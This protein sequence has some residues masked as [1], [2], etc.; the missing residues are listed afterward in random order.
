MDDLSVIFPVYNERKTIERVLQDWDTQLTKLKIPFRIIVCE[1]GSTDGTSQLLRQLVKRFGIKLL[2]RPQRSGYASAVTRGIK[3]AQTAYLLCVDSDGQCDP[4]D[5][6]DFW[7]KRSEAQDLLGFRKARADSLSRKLFSLLFKSVF[8]LLFD[9]SIRDPSCPF[10]LFRPGVIVPF[11]DKLALMREGFWWG[12][13]GMCVKNKLS[14]LQIPVRHRPRFDG[15]TNV[16]QLPK[17]PGIALRN[18]IG[19]LHLKFLS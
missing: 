12:F 9:A 6:F 17:I 7:Q 5:V 13:T 14:L 3:A 11:V 2:Q 15:Q 8:S 1:D 18:L 4:G 16:Y 10:V 19:L